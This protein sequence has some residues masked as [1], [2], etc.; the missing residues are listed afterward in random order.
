MEAEWYCQRQAG[1]AE[2]QDE[3]PFVPRAWPLET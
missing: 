1:D 3:V 2:E